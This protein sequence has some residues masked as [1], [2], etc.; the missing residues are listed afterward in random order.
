[1]EKVILTAEN[2]IM[3]TTKVDVEFKGNIEIQSLYDTSAINDLIKGALKL[4]LVNYDADKKINEKKFLK[5]LNKN[6]EPFLKI[7]DYEIKINKK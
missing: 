3:K 2:I 7:V 4:T 1:M 6:L 5:E